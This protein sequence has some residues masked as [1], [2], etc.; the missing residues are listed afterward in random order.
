M[1]VTTA[2]VGGCCCGGGGGG[3]SPCCEDS[4]PLPTAL[5]VEITASSCS[6]WTGA[7]GSLA[8]NADT[9]EWTGSVISDTET[10]NVTLYCDEGTDPDEFAW[11]WTCNSG[12]SG[13]RPSVTINSCDPLDMTVEWEMDVAGCDGCSIGDTFTA[14][15]YE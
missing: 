6:G 7:T 12:G 3:T 10:M 9:L 14:H 8:W 13:P 5:L 15:V 1:T 11:E 2:L 4:A